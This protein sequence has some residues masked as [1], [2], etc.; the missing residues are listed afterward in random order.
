[1]FNT[2]TFY[3]FYIL[4]MCVVIY[5]LLIHLHSTNMSNVYNV[6]VYES[7]TYSQDVQLHEIKCTKQLTE[8]H[9]GI[10]LL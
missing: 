4:R 1:M 10:H 3:M 6:H 9:I 5:V 2:S 8:I 7:L